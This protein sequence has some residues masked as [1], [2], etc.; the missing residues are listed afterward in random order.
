MYG[1]RF[2]SSDQRGPAAQLSV[3]F[4]LLTNE[5]ENKNLSYCWDSSRYDTV[6]YSGGSTNPGRNPEYDLCHCVS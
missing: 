5:R 3:L 2:H 4:Q 1:R 6:A